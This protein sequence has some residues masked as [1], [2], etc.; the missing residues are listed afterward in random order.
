MQRTSLCLCMCRQ[1]IIPFWIVVIISIGV[2]NCWA[3]AIGYSFSGS[4]IAPGSS[5]GVSVS[6]NAPFSGRFFFD[7]NDTSGGEPFGKYDTMVY[8]QNIPDGLF[9]TIGGLTISAD[10]YAVE[11]TNN[12][13]LSAS[14]SVDAVAILFYSS[15]S[16]APT[17]PIIVN[18]VSYSLGHFE[19]DF[20]GSSNLF[21]APT[22]P[23]SLSLTN[24]ST[25]HSAFLGDEVPANAIDLP[26]IT[27]NSLTQ[28]PDLAGDL[29]RDGH[30]NAADLIAMSQMLADQ[31]SYMTSY[32]IGQEKLLTLGDM[33]HSGTIDNADLQCLINN[34]KSGGGTITSVTEPS[35]FGL[36]TGVCCLWMA[37]VLRH[38]KNSDRS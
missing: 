4:V 28:I 30:V 33:N 8:P 7:P 3:E 22:M 25:T 26:F 18:G 16:P 27:V 34:L 37:S 32:H 20:Q 9:A 11:V 17:K 12:L 19:I 15:L 5:Y 1:I 13:P 2:V 14:S 29:N 24:Y 35:T 36:L 38:E 21:P 23:S 31:N 6:R 10:S